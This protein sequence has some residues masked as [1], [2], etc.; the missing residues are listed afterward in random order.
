MLKD[1]SFGVGEIRACLDLDHKD[2]FGRGGLNINMKKK[3]DDRLG[4]GKKE[5]YLWIERLAIIRGIAP[6]SIKSS[7][8]WFVVPLKF[9][10]CVFKNPITSCLAMVRTF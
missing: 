7:G 4:E 10:I 1:D 2:L 9:E 6:I 8:F 3:R 5:Q